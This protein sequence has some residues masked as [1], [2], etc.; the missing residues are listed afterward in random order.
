MSP[1]EGF[2]KGASFFGI[3]ISFLWYRDGLS[4][5]FGIEIS[6]L[7]IEILHSLVQ[8]LDHLLPGIDP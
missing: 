3:E 7:G 4:L 6:F 8:P 1:K 2:I 5:L